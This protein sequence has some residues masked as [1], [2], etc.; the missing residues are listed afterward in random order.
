[1]Q[2]TQ[3]LLVGGM[4][5]GVLHFALQSVLP[6]PSPVA[7]SEM[8]FDGGQIVATARIDTQEPIAAVWAGHI[9]SSAG[10]VAGRCEGSGYGIYH[11]GER[12][13]R[14]SLWRCGADDLTPGGVYEPVLSVIWG[15][16]QAT[17]IGGAFVYAGG[18][19]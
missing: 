4:A 1:M 17:F 15:K 3:V 11:P 5:V 12:E 16:D 18:G 7:V 13:L 9:R 14:F 2:V 10:D 19:Q 6:Q 8:R